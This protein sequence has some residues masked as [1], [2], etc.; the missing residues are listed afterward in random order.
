MRSHGM[1]KL[2]KLVINH[3]KYIGMEE[4]MYNKNEI[5]NMLYRLYDENKCSYEEMSAMK[6]INLMI[7]ELEKNID[8]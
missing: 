7:D 8:E 1:G 5:I 2:E 4:I 3:L 6:I